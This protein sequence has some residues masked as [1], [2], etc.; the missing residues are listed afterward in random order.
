M[1]PASDKV[2]QWLGHRQRDC[3]ES[4]SWLLVIHSMREAARS[5]ANSSQKRPNSCF[6]RNAPNYPGTLRPGDAGA[7]TS[8]AIVL[9]GGPGV[10]SFVGSKTDT[11]LVRD[12]QSE[13]S[14]HE[15]EFSSS[16][17]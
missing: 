7:A 9:Q 5:L 13:N 8:A 12:Y 1:N 6:A 2:P 16:Y 11:Q 14:A 3:F 15:S 17:T 10:A 4:A